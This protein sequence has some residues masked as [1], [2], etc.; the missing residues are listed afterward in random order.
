[1]NDRLERMV[2]LGW[3]IKQNRMEIDELEE[4]FAKL[5]KTPDAASPFAGIVEGAS[6][7]LAKGLQ[8][9][10]ETADIEGLR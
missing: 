8:V 1:M 10:P 6:N 2:E 3:L 5:D 9:V 4:E 7:I